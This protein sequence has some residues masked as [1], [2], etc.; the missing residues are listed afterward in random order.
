MADLLIEGA[1]TLNPA[2]RRDELVRVAAEGV[3]LINATGM[4]TVRCLVPF[5]NVILRPA[6]GRVPQR[7]VDGENGQD[8]RD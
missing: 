5:G 7:I 6:T 1:T 4:N 8:T 2:A 3:S